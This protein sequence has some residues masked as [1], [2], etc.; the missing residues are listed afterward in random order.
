MGAGLFCFLQCCLA[1]SAEASS[2]AEFEL[3]ALEPDI[4]AALSPFSTSVLLSIENPW[5]GLRHDLFVVILALV[6]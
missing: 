1:L 3:K 4:I 6:M 5:G 2:W